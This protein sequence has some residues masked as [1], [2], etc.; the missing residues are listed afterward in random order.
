MEKMKNNVKVQL[1]LF[2]LTCP[3]SLVN[4][5][6]CVNGNCYYFSNHT[7]RWLNARQYC[8][9]KGA[10]LAV[11][12]SKAN[13]DYL[14]SIMSKK[15]INKTF[16]GLFKTAPGLGSKFYKTDGHIQD[17]FYWG[18]MQ[19]CNLG[20]NEDCVEMIASD[21]FYTGGIHND[22][23]CSYERHF[24]CHIAGSCKGGK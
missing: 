21:P 20:G 2:V 15:G 23:P 10:D 8:L 13:N 11:P 16:I 18:N 3:W 24:I 9:D 12:F 19:P 4:G 1:L 7:A 5:W 14:Y 6:E 17:F 22:V